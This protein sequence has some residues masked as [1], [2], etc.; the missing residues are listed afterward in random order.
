MTVPA[1]KNAFRMPV[2]VRFHE[3][4]PLGHVNNAVYLT[5][6]EQAAIDHAAAVGWPQHVLERDVGGVFV[7]RRHEIDYLRPA[8]EGD[9][10]EVV[11]WAETMGMASA[12]R[13]YVIRKADG[14]GSAAPSGLIRAP[15]VPAFATGEVLVTAQTQWV[16]VRRESGRPMRVPQQVIDAFV[17][18]EQGEMPSD[19]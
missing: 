10:L 5:Y 8:V 17:E 13:R 16:L 12:I 6:L 1:P 7:A 19:R 15:D 4:D 9:K 14:T 3:C 2:R 18:P 11:T